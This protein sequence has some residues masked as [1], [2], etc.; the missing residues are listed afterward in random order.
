MANRKLLAEIDRVLKKVDEG[1]AIFEQIWDKV[2]SATTTAQKEKYEGDL[3]KEIK[4][5]QRLR[6][7]IKNWQGDSSIKD[8]TKLDANRKLIEEK[9]EKF[10]IC[11]KETK[12]KA[13]SKEGLAQDR[14]DPKQKAKAE[15]GDWVRDAISRIREQSDEFEAEIEQVMSGKRKKRG[16]DPPRVGELK[17]AISRHE[18][19]VEMLERVL[20]AVDNDQVSPEQCNNELRE[21]VDY[22]LESNQEADFV[23]DDEMYDTLNLEAVPAITPM[24]NAPPSPPAPTVVSSSLSI[25][26]SLPKK[27][28]DTLSSK[29]SKGNGNGVPDASPS[30]AGAALSAAANAAAAA[31][32]ALNAANAAAAASAALA[33]DDNIV[34]PVRSGR[35]GRSGG[36]D[37]SLSSPASRL[38]VPRPGG[39][40]ALHVSAHHA[41]VDVV[42]P[43]SQPQQPPLM[44]SVVKGQPS[45]SA[46]VAAAANAQ[47]A[48]LLHQQN[49]QELLNMQQQQQMLHVRMQQQQQQ[50][51]RLQQQRKQQ[52]QRSS[53]TAEGTAAIPVPGEAIAV[54]VA[55]VAPVPEVVRGIP[56][57]GIPSAPELPPSAGISPSAEVSE[58]RALD[59]AKS[60]M[61]E[62]QGASRHQFP[63]NPP[64]SRN[65]VPTPPSFPSVAA[66]V[67][68]SGA[69]FEKF[70]PDTLFFIFYYQQGTRQQYLAARELK[71]QGWRFHKKYLTWFQ[72]HE[73]PKVSTDEYEVG[74]L[75]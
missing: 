45:T 22:Y 43:V 48:A 41:P 58:L 30:A 12:T 60:M 9:M 13:F 47:H 70:D 23:E 1:V 68:E 56:P 26:A 35:G 32:A 24:V 38:G 4:K 61:P 5:L 16:E 72:R 3:K 62:P 20:R 57:L 25:G 71:R 44:S 19:H 66:S 42:S 2:Y 53:A 74:A 73:E 51:Q 67:F 7:Q 33:D 31:A 52:Q 65:L 27:V 63:A 28:P 6:D 49:Q 8:K 34:S 55:S 36:V 21:L 37:V 18:Y 40:G 17:D 69:I 54:D 64:A 10:K 29:V 75:C 39:I 14:T 50:Q 46:A 15:V 11:E 59:A